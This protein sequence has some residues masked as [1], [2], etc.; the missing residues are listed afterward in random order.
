MGKKKLFVLLL[1]LLSV[2][3]IIYLIGRNDVGSEADDIGASS[4]N[5][6]YIGLRDSIFD[7]GKRNWDMVRY[8]ALSNEL[9]QLYTQKPVQLLDEK[10]HASL[11]SLLANEYFAVLVRQTEVFCKTASPGDPTGKLLKEEMDRRFDASFQAERKSILKNSIQGFYEGASLSDR[12]M[13]YVGSEAYRKSKTDSY[14]ALAGDISGDPLLRENRSLMSICSQSRGYLAAHRQLDE[15]LEKLMAN[16][17]MEYCGAAI[18]SNPVHRTF[19]HYVNLC[20][21]SKK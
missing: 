13:K 10:E 21:N 6:V 17:A 7:M 3:L 5:P 4:K 8:Q 16:D 19:R 15:S 14:L 20:N 12:V 2:S 18:E 9:N 11:S 1:S